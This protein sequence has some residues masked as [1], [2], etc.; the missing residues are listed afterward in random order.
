MINAL[1]LPAGV[2]FRLFRSRRSLLL[3]NLALRQQLT[4]LKRGQSAGYGSRTCPQPFSRPRAYSAN[5][6]EFLY[7]MK[8][9]RINM[10]QKTS[11]QVSGTQRESSSVA[12]WPG[13]A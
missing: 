11:D 1:G 5:R 3:E 7:Q 13:T 6:A 4:V 2:I 9:E 12:N 8:W 10:L